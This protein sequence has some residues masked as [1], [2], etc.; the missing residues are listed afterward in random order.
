MITI[1][2]HIYTIFTGKIN[3]KKPSESLL[4][5][6]RENFYYLFVILPWASHLFT[7]FS[8]QTKKRNVFINW[9]LYFFGHLS[10]LQSSHINVTKKRTSTRLARIIFFFFVI[11]PWASPHFSLSSHQPTKMTIYEAGSKYSKPFQDFRF[12]V[13]LSLLYRPQLHWNEDR[14][15]SFF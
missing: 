4:F 15:L 1:F 9:L 5:L 6:E 10:F 11:T 13:H 14:N 3:M 2:L 7:F 12:V 8:H